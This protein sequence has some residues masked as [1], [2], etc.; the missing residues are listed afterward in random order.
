MPQITTVDFPTPF[1]P[2]K[3]GEHWFYDTGAREVKLSNLP[4]ILFP[5]RGYTKGDVLAY[6]A[7]IAD[8]ILPYMRD[9]PLT[10]WRMPDGV[11]AEGF[12]EKQAPS[13]T[14][15][16]MPRARVEGHSRSRA[17]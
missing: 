10:L 14:P 5:E 2:V 8:T 1:E 11:G 12:F 16:W 15:E 17:I 7:N 13:H 3:R 6:Y 4:K 9:R